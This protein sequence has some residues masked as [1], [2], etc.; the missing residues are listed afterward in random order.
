MPKKPHLKP[1]PKACDCSGSNCNAASFRASFSSDSLNDSKSPESK[2]Y[3]AANTWGFIGL[4]P[5]RELFLSG[6]T[7]VSPTGAPLILL[8]PEQIKP[9]SPAESLF[10]SNLL[11]VK[12]PN[13]S[14]T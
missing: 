10:F 5:G 9:T 7:I 13:F 8:T 6:N 1:E 12:T 11:G 3:K 14:T 4:K 2:G